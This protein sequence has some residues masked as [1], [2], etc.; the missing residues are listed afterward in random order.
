MNEDIIEVIVY[1]TLAILACIGL[2]YVNRKTDYIT[3]A[4][5]FFIIVLIMLLLGIIIILFINYG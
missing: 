3:K 2:L 1:C 5:K 4:E